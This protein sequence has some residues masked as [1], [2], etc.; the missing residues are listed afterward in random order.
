MGLKLKNNAKSTLAATV[1]AA[2]TSIAL[3][4]GHGSRFPVLEAGDWFP[5]ALVDTSGNVEYM[6]ATARNGDSVTVLRAQEGT[7]ARVFASGSAVMLPLT[8]DAIAALEIGSSPLA[9]SIGNS[10]VSQ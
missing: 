6:K 9:V 7:Q 8:V 10:V 3:A 2:Q 5:L 4:A 1:T